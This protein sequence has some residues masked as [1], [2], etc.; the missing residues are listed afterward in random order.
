MTYTV[1]GGTLNST[2][3][4]THSLTHLLYQRTV[5][6][7]HRCLVGSYRLVVLDILHSWLWHSS[8]PIGIITAHVCRFRKDLFHIW[9][10]QNYISVL[11]EFIKT[12]LPLDTADMHTHE[13]AL[14]LGMYRISGSNSSWPDI[15]FRS[16]ILR[17]SEM[18]PFNRSPMSYYLTSDQMMYF[19]RTISEI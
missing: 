11:T 4:L 2:H 7:R 10:A 15:R 14:V 12:P 6:C 9:T 3:S 5:S 16:P 18:S 1:L 19:Y 17:L 8:R 13:H